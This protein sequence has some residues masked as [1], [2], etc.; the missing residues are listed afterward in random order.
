[1]RKFIPYHLS[2]VADERTS[3]KEWLMPRIEQIIADDPRLPPYERDVLEA[4]D[5][6]P[7][8]LFRRDKKADLQELRAWILAP[9]EP[10]PPLSLVDSRVQ[11]ISILEH[12]MASLHHKRAIGCIVI[13]EYHCYGSHE[14]IR[15]AKAELNAQNIEWQEIFPQDVPEQPD[16]DVEV[17]V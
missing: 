16:V 4:M 10:E 9:D 17:A 1:M 13:N 14:A 7:D 11:P 6:H 2:S 5:N 12:T 15:N 8:Y 3:L